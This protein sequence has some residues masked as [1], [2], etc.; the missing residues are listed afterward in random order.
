[1]SM[2]KE[3]YIRV[4]G[5]REKSQAP[6]NKLS[7]I[8]NDISPWVTIVEHAGK[9]TDGNERFEVQNPLGDVFT[10]VNVITLYLHMTF[11]PN[12]MFIGKARSL[13]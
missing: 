7:I 13:P 1:M 4:N 5:I 10:V 9:S 2:R 8:I 6:L 11:Q 3:N 12:L